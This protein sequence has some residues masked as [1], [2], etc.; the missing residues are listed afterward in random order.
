MFGMFDWLK[1]LFTLKITTWYLVKDRCGGKIIE[2]RTNQRME[3][4]YFKTYK[5]RLL[6]QGYYE[7]D[8]NTFNK[9]KG[10]Q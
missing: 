10:E 6:K 1:E 8:E 2:F 4:S 5:N 7:V 3:A 9:L